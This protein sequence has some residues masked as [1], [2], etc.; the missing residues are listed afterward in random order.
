MKVAHAGPNFAGHFAI[1]V[2]GCGM[3]C[4]EFAIIDEVSGLVIDPPLSAVAAGD[5]RGFVQDFGLHYRLDSNFLI[6]VGC[7]NE[8]N[9]ASRSYVLSGGKLSFLSRS[10]VKRATTSAR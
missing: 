4:A 10:A 6:V 3:G 1:A 8:R 2:W 5:E 9:C 7:P